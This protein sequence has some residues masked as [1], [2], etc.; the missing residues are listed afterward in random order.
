MVIIIIAFLWLHYFFGY[1]ILLKIQ[2]EKCLKVCL[3]ES[4]KSQKVMA[5]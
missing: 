4:V 1:F 3:L 2:R 5:I